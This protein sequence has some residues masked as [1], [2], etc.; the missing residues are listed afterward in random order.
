LNKWNHVAATFD[1]DWIKIYLN[2]N[3]VFE[4]NCN[5]A[6]KYTN[7][8]SVYIGCDRENGSPYYFFKGKIDNVRIWNVARTQPQIHNDMYTP[9]QVGGNNQN[10]SFFLGLKASY[11]LMATAMTRAE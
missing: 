1:F 11:N 10:A 5:S 9:L 2:G 8:D 3:L 6:S 4:K 7:T